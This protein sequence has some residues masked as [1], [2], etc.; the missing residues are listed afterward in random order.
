MAK[1]KKAVKEESVTPAEIETVQE[2]APEVVAESEITPE[3][4]TE[5]ADETIFVT[6]PLQSDTIEPS[7]LT[8][9]QAFEMVEIQE[10]IK[11]ELP[12]AKKSLSELDKFLDDSNGEEV[13]LNEFFT[14]EKT[15]K[16]TIKKLVFSGK[17]VMSD[18]HWTD[19]GMHYYGKDGKSK[20][21]LLSDIKI[22]AKK[23]DFLCRN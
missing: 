10:E 15:A 11:E 6:V 23:S 5:V 9:E 21:Y 20:K 18:A 4:I 19:L 17:I 1:K 8:W 12:K 2:S 16:A 7:E 22:L 3:E 14:D 13:E